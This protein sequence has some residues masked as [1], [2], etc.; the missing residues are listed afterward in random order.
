[1]SNVIR[2]KVDYLFQQGDLRIVL[3]FLLR[4]ACVIVKVFPEWWEKSSTQ[5]L[6]KPESSLGSNQGDGDRD[7]SFLFGIQAL[8]DSNGFI[9]ILGKFYAPNAANEFGFLRSAMLNSWTSI[10]IVQRRA[11]KCLCKTFPWTSLSL[12]FF[13][14]AYPELKD[15]IPTAANLRLILVST[16]VQLSPNPGQR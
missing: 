9:L 1:M 11:W 4:I 7:R 13:G 2:K 16:P 15:S 3:Y 10:F 8:E 12:R 6:R 5:P 14:T